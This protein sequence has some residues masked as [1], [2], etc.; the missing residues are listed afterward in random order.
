LPIY[1]ET[2]NLVLNLFKLTK[3]FNR[4]YKYTIGQEMKHSSMQMVQYIF[5][6]NS[7]K[8]KVL[9]L[10]DLSDCFEILKLQLRLCVDMRLISSQ[11]HAEI[12][13]SLDAIGRQLT[14][15]KRANS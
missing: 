1:K 7:T 14:G 8:D 12:W 2:Y 11:Q 6:A 10:S 9:V 4:E 5:K 13:S 15:W 3:N